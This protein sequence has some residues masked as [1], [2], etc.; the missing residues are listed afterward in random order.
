[1]SRRGFSDSPGKDLFC[2][3]QLDFKFGWGYE[4]GLSVKETAGLI[5]IPGAIVPEFSKPK[6]R[7]K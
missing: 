3:F 5:I 4:R 6:W 7:E 2:D 1:L